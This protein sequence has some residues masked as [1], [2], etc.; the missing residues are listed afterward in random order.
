MSHKGALG[1]KTVSGITIFRDN[2]PPGVS[3]DLLPFVQ[4]LF[5]FVDV[6]KDNIDDDSD[7]EMPDVPAGK[8]KRDSPVQALYA[9][10]T[11][12]VHRLD[13]G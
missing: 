13:L 6:D 10:N 2:I 7:E 3:E 9:N 12:R 4:L 8:A 11:V 5:R 1:I